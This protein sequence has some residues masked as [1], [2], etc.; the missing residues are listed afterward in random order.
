MWSVRL[1]K[2]RECSE[3]I[4]AFPFSFS[5][6]GAAGPFLFSSFT[7]LSLL[8]GSTSELLLVVLSTGDCGWLDTGLLGPFS[9][10]GGG[11]GGRVFFTV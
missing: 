7:L 2:G 1:G 11:D 10:A 6:S 8:D 4:G 5:F 3:D 9:D